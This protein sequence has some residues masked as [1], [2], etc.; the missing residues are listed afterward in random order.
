MTFPEIFLST[1]QLASRVS[2]ELKE[3]GAQEQLGATNAFRDAQQADAEG[4]RLV[5]P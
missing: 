3:A 1:P 2:R 5:L 4:V